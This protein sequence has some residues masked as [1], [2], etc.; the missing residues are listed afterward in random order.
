MWAFAT[1]VVCPPQGAIATPFEERKKRTKNEGRRVYLGWALAAPGA[2]CPP[3]WAIA[4]PF[5]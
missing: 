2:V 1:G 5:G 4:A 3:Q